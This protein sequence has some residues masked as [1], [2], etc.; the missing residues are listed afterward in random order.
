MI[1]EET[2]ADRDRE[3]AALR[4]ERVDY[5]ETL[6]FGT[7]EAV[8]LF[9]PAHEPPDNRDELEGLFQ[10]YRWLDLNC[11]LRTAMHRAAEDIH[12]E[13]REL[14][15]ETR[16]RDCL[17][18]GSGVGTHTI[19]L[20]ENNNRVTMVDVAGALSAFAKR[21]IKGRS[22]SFKFINTRDPLPEAAF[23]LA[24]CVNVLEYCFDPADELARV[25]AALRPGGMLCLAVNDEEST[26]E[27]RFPA[28]LKQW[29]EKGVPL[30]EQRFEKVGE[31]L[32][33]KR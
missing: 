17:D 25:Q 24:L 30:L 5:I 6:D 28:M 19:A 21:R 27:G 23:D 32:Y 33:R 9:N 29:R 3:L 12:P 20:C 11:Y 7:G 13:L 18:F 15:A 1:L 4:G 2:Q 31:T 10:E 16:D 14:L 26:E 8:R 22:L